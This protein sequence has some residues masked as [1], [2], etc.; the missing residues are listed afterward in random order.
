MSSKRP[1]VNPLLGASNFKIEDSFGPQPALIV[2][3]ATSTPASAS[4][5]PFLGVKTH[6]QSSS[7]GPPPVMSLG[8]PQPGLFLLPTSTGTPNPPPVMTLTGTKPRSRYVPPPGIH[9]SSSSGSLNMMS[10]VMTPTSMIPPTIPAM[11][12]S[13][14]MPVILPPAQTI[15]YRQGPEL[16]PGQNERA[17]ELPKV[18]APDE[19]LFHWYYK[20]LEK[21][22]NVL[23]PT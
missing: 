12:S 23:N 17:V 1:S 14:S 8:P 9:A 21:Q 3:T 6:Q 5:D 18:A 11:Q 15:S 22:Y 19:P 13:P 7:L 4:N 20:V 16:Y 2:P 10:S